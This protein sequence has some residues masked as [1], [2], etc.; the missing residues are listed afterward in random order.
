MTHENL[1]YCFCEARKSQAFYTNCL[2]KAKTEEEKN[3]LIELVKSA[4]QTSNEIRQICELIDTN[5]E[6]K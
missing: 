2:N 3:I 6:H 4:A 1:F 5:G